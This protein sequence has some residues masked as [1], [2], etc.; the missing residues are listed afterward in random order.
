S[1][2]QLVSSS[3]GEPA[4]GGANIGFSA[5]ELDDLRERA[6]IFDQ[7]SAV[8]PVSANVTGG[9]HPERI[10][11]LAGSPSYFSILGVAP[12]LGRI[13]GP[14]D[15]AL[16]FADACVLSDAAWHRLFAADRSVLGKR[17]Y[18][19]GDAYTVVGI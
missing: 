8:W 3:A 1:P 18:L 5:L 17:V 7:V 11:L 16:G 19:D 15:E 2:S 9:S 4:A 10:E 6:G 13:F 14:E 12:Q